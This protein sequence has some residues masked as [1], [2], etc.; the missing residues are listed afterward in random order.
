[1]R[2]GDDV[3]RSTSDAPS[4]PPPPPSSLQGTHASM[5]V[6]KKWSL[7]HCGIQ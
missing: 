4:L 7:A 3:K 2:V 1:M 6:L 5:S